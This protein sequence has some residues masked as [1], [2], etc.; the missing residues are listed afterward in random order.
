MTT[1]RTTPQRHGPPLWLGLLTLL[2][3]TCNRDDLTARADEAMLLM[4]SEARALQRRADLHL[5]DG[6]VTAAISDVREVLAIRFPATSPEGEDA[7]LDAH[8]RLARLLLAQGGDEAEHKALA[9]I[10]AGRKLATRDSFFRAHL[11]SVAAEIYEARAKRQSDPSAAKEARKEA[12]R[13][14]ERAIAIDRHL[15]RILLSLPDL[16]EE[17]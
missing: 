13:A 6:D 2:L 17:H 7:L 5:L 4:L 11:E 14:L 16:P 10:E 12:M 15:Q 1:P 3:A 8:G 9:Q